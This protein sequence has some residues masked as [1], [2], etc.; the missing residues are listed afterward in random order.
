VCVRVCVPVVDEARRGSEHLKRLV[1]AITDLLEQRRVSKQGDTAMLPWRCVML[2]RCCVMLSQ[3][4]VM[5]WYLSRK[6]AGS[7]SSFLIALRVFC[8]TTPFIRAL[9]GL[10][11]TLGVLRSSGL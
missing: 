2:S 1:D 11:G 4:T 10:G 9:E 5:L 7:A 6:A 8:A 3:R